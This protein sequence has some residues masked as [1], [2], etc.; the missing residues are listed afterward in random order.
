MHVDTNLSMYMQV[1]YITAIVI[2]HAGTNTQ[3]RDRPQPTTCIRADGRVPTYALIYVYRQ[4]CICF[5]A[6]KFLTEGQRRTG[7]TERATDR[8]THTHI[9]RVTPHS[10]RPSSTYTCR[11]LLAARI[12]TRP[13]THPRRDKYMNPGRGAYRRRSLRHTCHHPRTCRC[14]AG[15]S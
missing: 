14:P 1:A 4:T 8:Q 2:M 6:R 13:H 12:E 10:T 7:K 9:V 5:M 11:G 15:V 3:L